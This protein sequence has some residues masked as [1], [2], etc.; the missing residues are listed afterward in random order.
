MEE[1]PRQPANPEIPADVLKLR[2]ELLSLAPDRKR[3]A[4]FLAS[5]VAARKP[6]HA[7][8][9]VA[10]EALA[11]HL[12]DASE[13]ET[14][15]EAAAIHDADAA[16]LRAAGFAPAARLED[17]P[18]GSADLLVVRAC[19]EFAASP[20]AL[21]KEFHRIL[22][23][24]GQLLLHVRRKRSSL[25]AWAREAAGLADA[26][27]KRAKSA[28]TPQEIYDILKDGFDIEDTYAQGKFFTVFCELVASLFSGVL[29]ETAEA[30]AMR[31]GPLKRAKAVWLAMRPFFWLAALLDAVCFWLPKHEMVFRAK[32]RMLWVPR[33]TPRLKD[34]RSIAEAALGSKIGTAV[35]QD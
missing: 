1:E 15:W 23:P 34:G 7:V 5:A 12:R 24:K 27:R 14:A 32:R 8:S 19:F 16:L 13:G 10:D 4:A 30:A 6:A 11:A 21:A 25:L 3:L 29:P 2:R 26:T 17:V 22:A 28:F 20:V 9:Y 18:A 31:P 33:L 35:G